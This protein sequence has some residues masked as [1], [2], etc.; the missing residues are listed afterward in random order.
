MLDLQNLFEGDLHDCQ[1]KP[2]PG[3]I[4]EIGCLVCIHLFEM[5]NTAS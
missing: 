5:N 4:C 1:F 2:Q 3:K